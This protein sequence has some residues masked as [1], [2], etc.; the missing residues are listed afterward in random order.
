M[1]VQKSYDRL[2]DKGLPVID[3]SAN[4][5]RVSFVRRVLGR[6][7]VR[8]HNDAMTTLNVRARDLF[9]PNADARVL[10]LGT[11]DAVL[12][13]FFAQRIRPRERFG[14]DVAPVER[15]DITVV[16]SD[17]ERPL[18]FADA[19]FDV[20]ISSQNIEHIIDTPQYCREIHRVLKPGGY[21]VVLTENLSS[22][23]NIACLVMGWEPVSLANQFGKTLG[24]PFVWHSELHTNE[25]VQG[26]YAKRW[27]G[28]LGHQRVFAPKALA[29]LFTEE[30]FS[31]DAQIGGGYGV[32]WGGVQRFLSW[33][34][35]KHSHF[36]GLRAR[37]PM[38]M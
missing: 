17:L 38:R 3:Q 5:A 23:I 11:G 16:A 29:Q 21:A 9:V 28:A 4:L 22:W 2:D 20:V 15:G 19:M 7:A 26:L 10:D 18:P 24:N 35:V 1:G 37:K 13:D 14:V 27:W 12:Y 8:V 6:I 31:I 25:T 33:C 34:D 32:T 36:I 30:G